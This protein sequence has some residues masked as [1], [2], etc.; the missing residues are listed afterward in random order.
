MEQISAA[1]EYISMR[2]TVGRRLTSWR[3]AEC[4][5]YS[6]SLPCGRIVSEIEDVS[7]Q[8]DG[9][10]AFERNFVHSDTRIAN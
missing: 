8:C 4:S 5:M 9:K 1:V 10:L 6:V 2:S 3:D 7:T